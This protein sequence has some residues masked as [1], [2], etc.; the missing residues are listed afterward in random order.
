MQN[1]NFINK[2][3]IILEIIIPIIMFIVLFFCFNLGI[4]YRYFFH[5]P[6]TWTYELS[7]ASFM[8]FVI[9]SI[10]Y[11]NR[12][13]AN[14]SFDLIY[15]KRSRK[16][17]MLFNLLSNIFTMICCILLFFASI[18]YC[19]SMNGLYL[20][21]INISKYLVFLCFPIVFL[22]IVFQSLDNILR[23]TKLRDRL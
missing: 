23:I 21:S 10:P 6:Q 2:L 13:N 12:K 19:N 11:V 9:F 3:T 8:N 1:N 15:N 7:M 17:K 14:V 22:D 16:T 18:K 4:V 20:Q 5:N